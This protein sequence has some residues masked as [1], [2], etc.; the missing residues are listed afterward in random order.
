[1]ILVHGDYFPSCLRRMPLAIT[2]RTKRSHQ[3]GVAAAYTLEGANRHAHVTRRP[4]LCTNLTI[5]Y[6][7]AGRAHGLATITQTTLPSVFR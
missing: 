5:R 4:R 6:D 2:R 1:M 3:P 7:T